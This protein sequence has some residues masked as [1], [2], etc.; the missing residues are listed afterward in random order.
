MIG[1]ISATVP[2]LLTKAPI[3]EVVSMTSRKARVSLPWARPIIRLPVSR[4]S[5]VW[6]MAP[7][8]TKRPAIMMTTEEEKPAK[9]SVGLSTPETNNT[10]RAESATTSLRMRPQMKRATVRPRTISVSVIFLGL[11]YRIPRLILTDCER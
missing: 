6:K 1:I 9:A 2:V 5:P 10:A 11:Y 3:T 4:A 7:P 8:T